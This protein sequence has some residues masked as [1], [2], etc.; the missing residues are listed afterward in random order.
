MN[1]IITQQ[2]EN[3]EIS[4]DVYSKLVESR[5]LFLQGYIDD[6]IA[7]DISATLLFMDSQNDTDQ[8]SLYINSE[9][10]DT[11]S[12][13]MIY[14]IMKM[15]ASPVQTLCTGSAFH[16]ASL[17]LAAG[18]NGLRLATQ[19][20]TICLAQ[21]DHNGSDYGNLQKAEAI[22]HQSKKDNDKFMTALADCTGKNI[23]TLMKDLAQPVYMSPKQA[24]KYSIIDRI[25]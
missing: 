18:T 13:F 15:I 3:G 9:G 20:A 1:T 23:K 7:T 11:R 5:I 12:V 22:L 19:N 4:F 8:I 25:L 24:L 17:I 10:G 21:L 16:E 2:T 6:A 14:D